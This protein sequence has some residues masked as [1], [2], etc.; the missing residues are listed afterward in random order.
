MKTKDLLRQHLSWLHSRNTL[1]IDGICDHCCGLCDPL[2][3]AE[4][5]VKQHPGSKTCAE[6]VAREQQRQNAA[7]AREAENIVFIVAPQGVDE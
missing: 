3:P 6:G 1:T 5:L 4:W 7:A 2:V